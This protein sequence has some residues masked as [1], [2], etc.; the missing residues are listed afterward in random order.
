MAA[1]EPTLRMIRSLGPAGFDKE[2]PFGDESR[3]SPDD[4]ASTLND[5]GDK[6]WAVVAIN[7]IREPDRLL[8]VLRREVPA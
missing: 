6:G 7:T 5:L 3:L 1:S 4:W 2:Q 8:W